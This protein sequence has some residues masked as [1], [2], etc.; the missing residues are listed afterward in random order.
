[1]A[2]ARTT[3]DIILDT[4]VEMFNEQGTAAVST[5]HIAAAAGIS[6]GNL[7]YHFRNKEDIIRSILD[8]MYED[9]NAVYQVPA[10]ASFDLDIL[11]QALRKNFDLLWRYRLFYRELVTLVRHDR[12]LGNRHTAIQRQRQREQLA[13][14]DRL[15][16]AGVFK[17]PRQRSDVEATLTVAW[18][19]GSYWLAYL[20]S[21]G[22]AVTPELVQQGVNLVAGL[23]TS[24]LNL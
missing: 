18:I 10:D 3:R 8:R 11:R 21:S 14:F 16:A 4:A 13:L 7:Y 23:Y 22:E 20:E 9:W 24:Y 12:E 19:V 5:N 6:P 15:A 2:R 17:W 1:M